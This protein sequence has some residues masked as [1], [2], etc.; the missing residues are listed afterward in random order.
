ML[1]MECLVHRFLRM[2]RIYNGCHGRGWQQCVDPDRDK[3]L[4]CKYG[5]ASCQAAAAAVHRHVGSQH[6]Q[7][8]GG[9]GHAAAVLV[10][11]SVRSTRSGYWAHV[12]NIKGRE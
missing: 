2:E 6:S 10:Q 4:N 8:I 9:S 12:D 11:S 5:R 3:Q 1:Q 7:E